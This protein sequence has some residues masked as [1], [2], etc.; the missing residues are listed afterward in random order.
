MVKR[1][2]LFLLIIFSIF[3]VIVSLIFFIYNSTHSSIAYIYN[4]KFYDEN[5]IYPS[6]SYIISSFYNGELSFETINKSI[7]N[8]CSNVIRDLYNTF[9]GANTNEN[10]NKYFNSNKSNIR[11]NIGLSNYDDFYELVTEICKLDCDDLVL[12]RIELESSDSESDELEF[13][14][15]I[16]AVYEGDKELRFRALIEDD[17]I[18]KKYS[19]IKYTISK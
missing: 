15:T 6:H 1:R 8:F 13:E 9:N 17:I 16:V 19:P 2:L 14:C 7:N 4:E 3:I 5:L 18:S 10:I 12:K 11:A